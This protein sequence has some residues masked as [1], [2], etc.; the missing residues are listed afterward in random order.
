MIAYAGERAELDKNLLGGLPLH[1]SVLNAQEARRSQ[2]SRG[3][4][5]HHSDRIQPVGTGK[6]R[7]QRVMITRLGDY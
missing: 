1:I 6:Q 7:D 4:G 5:G 3:L 2:Q